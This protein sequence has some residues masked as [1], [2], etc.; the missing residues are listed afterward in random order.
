MFFNGIGFVDI[1]ATY[2]FTTPLVEGQKLYRSFLKMV[3]YLSVT[4][5]H[6]VSEL[7]ITD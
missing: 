1:S 5:E 2:E 6:H 3:D 7:L 4:M